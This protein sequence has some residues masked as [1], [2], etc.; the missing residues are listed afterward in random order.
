MW[1]FHDN[2]STIVKPR[3]FVFLLLVIRL[4]SNIIFESGIWLFF[5]RNCKQVVLSRFRDNRLFLNHSLTSAKILLSLLANSVGLGLLIMKM[6]SSAYNTNLVLLAF[7][8]G[9]SFMYNRK[10]KGPRIEPCGT[11]YLT[12]SQCE[13]VLSLIATL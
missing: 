11:P 4:F 10:S 5:V 8:K 12:S 1:H 2:V 6:V 13:L 7:T 3:N 9:K